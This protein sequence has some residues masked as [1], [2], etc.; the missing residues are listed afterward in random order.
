MQDTLYG[1]LMARL[2]KPQSGTLLTKIWWAMEQID[3]CI[4]VDQSPISRSPRSNPVTYVK[5]FDENR[6]VFAETMDARMHNYGPSHFSFNSDLGRCL[7][8]QG[9][10]VQEIDM[11][12]MADIYVT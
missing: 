12:F 8:C 3:D 2:N 10:G 1:A 9:D 4:L 6:Q 11:Q 5:A 7:T